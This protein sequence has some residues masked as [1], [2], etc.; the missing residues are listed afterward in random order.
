ME[1]HIV[2]KF[3]S[4]IE[5]IEFYEIIDNY[6]YFALLRRQGTDEYYIWDDNFSV[7]SHKFELEEL[8]KTRKDYKQLFI[9]TE[10]DWYYGVVFFWAD[11]KFVT[12]YGMPNYNMLINIYNQ[13]VDLRESEWHINNDLAYIRD[14]EGIFSYIRCSWMALSHRRRQKPIIKNL[15]KEFKIIW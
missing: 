7:L 6:K 4:K 8:P 10:R 15:E 11:S 14:N 2:A 3:D 13:L 5:K 1:K 12:E 9:D